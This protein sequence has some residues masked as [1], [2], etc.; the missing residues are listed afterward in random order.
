MISIGADEK[1]PTIAS[2]IRNTTAASHSG[3][4]A[5]SRYFRIRST[6]FLALSPS[7]SMYWPKWPPVDITPTPSSSVLG[8][9]DGK[10]WSLPFL[11]SR[12]Q[13]ILPYLFPQY[14]WRG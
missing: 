13:K 5:I 1:S 6:S 3:C 9:K 12:N 7:I 14:Y 10:A 11:W 2:S 4:V 8:T